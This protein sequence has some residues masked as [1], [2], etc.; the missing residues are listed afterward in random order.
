MTQPPHAVGL[1]L[2][3]KVFDRQQSL[4]ADGVKDN[5]HGY[6]MAVLLIF[7]SDN[8]LM[9]IKHVHIGLI[10]CCVGSELT[11]QDGILPF[12]KSI[13]SGLAEVREKQ[14]EGMEVSQPHSYFL[15]IANYG[16]RWPS[17]WS[18]LSASCIP[19]CMMMT[20]WKKPTSTPWA[21][22]QEC[23]L[24]PVCVILCSISWMQIPTTD[25]SSRGVTC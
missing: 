7:L 8:E 21:I 15:L 18:H 11:N 13:E 24:R 22:H 3:P 1:S 14:E 25:R 5:L 23:A 19:L 17:P 12:V 4:Q 20:Q 6:S 10:V 9:V 2:P 16:V